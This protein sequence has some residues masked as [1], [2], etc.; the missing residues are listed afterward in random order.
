MD[1][2]IIIDPEVQHIPFQFKREMEM[3][4]HVDADLPTSDR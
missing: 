4:F 2:R 3:R 1:E